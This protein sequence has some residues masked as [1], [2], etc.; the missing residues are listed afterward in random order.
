G[1]SPRDADARIPAFCL[2]DPLKSYTFEE[3]DFE[4]GPMPRISVPGFINPAF[5]LVSAP[6]SEHPISAVQLI[7]RLQ[8]LQRALDNLPAQ[9]RRLARWQAR[10]D[11]VL[12]G[13]TTRKITRL[14]PFRPGRP[15]GFRQHPIHDVDDILLECHNLMLD[16]SD[17][18]NTS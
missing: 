7:R 11:S 8:A 17:L 18:P 6:S 3:P 12:R 13:G 5:V 16:V 14:S 4:A 1:L 15:P 2:I 10:R 9:A